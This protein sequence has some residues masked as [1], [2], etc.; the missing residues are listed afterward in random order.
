MRNVVDHPKTKP[1]APLVVANFTLN[2]FD[3][4]LML[5]EPEWFLTGEAIRPLLASFDLIIESIICLGEAMLT[6]LF[7]KLRAI[8]ILV[9][10]EIP[11]EL[12]DPASPVALRVTISDAKAP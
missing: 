4:S 12:R 10:E 11:V 8:D 9:I 1:G 2:E 7:Y 3:G 6:E 5:M